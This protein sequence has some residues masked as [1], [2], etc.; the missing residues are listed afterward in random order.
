VLLSELLVDGDVVAL[1]SVL[2]EVEDVVVSEIDVLVVDVDVVGVFDDDVLV[3]LED[4]AVLSELVELLLVVAV[5]SE[6]VDVLESED[7]EVVDVDVVRVVG[8]V[9]VLVDE[10][11]VLDVL[12]LVLGVF[13]DGEVGLL[14][15]VDVLVDGVFDSDVDVVTVDGVSDRL[16]FELDVSVV[17]VLVDGVFEVDVSDVLLVVRLPALKN[18]LMLFPPLLLLPSVAS[19][20]VSLLQ[21]VTSVLR[22]AEGAPVK[23]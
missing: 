3:S 15:D 12:V 14:V 4:V 23:L 8:D 16:V 19:M 21:S 22:T 6:L 9:L 10:S 20:A 7:V 2:V 18:Q 17:L 1:V 11:E 13:E 5:L